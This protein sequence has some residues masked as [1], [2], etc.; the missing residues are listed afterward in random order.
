MSLGKTAIAQLSPVPEEA[1]PDISAKGDDQCEEAGSAC[2]NLASVFDMCE[3]SEEGNKAAKEGGEEKEKEQKIQS[4]G[5]IDTS[6]LAPMAPPAPPVSGHL[7]LLITCM[8]VLWP[9]WYF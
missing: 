3:D 8:L 1:M 4:N 7:F 6:L 2:A 9:W 5:T